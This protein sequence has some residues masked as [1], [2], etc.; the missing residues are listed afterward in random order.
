MLSG[1]LRS[2]TDAGDTV[3]VPR[4]PTVHPF[5]GD[6]MATAYAFRPVANDYT[7]LFTQLRVAGVLV[8]TDATPG[9]VTGSVTCSTSQEASSPR[10]CGSGW[11]STASPRAALP[12]P[13]AAS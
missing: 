7:P 4:A 3:G 1:G 8:D 2:R 10:R 9:L 13:D 6:V 11:R 5:A 12:P